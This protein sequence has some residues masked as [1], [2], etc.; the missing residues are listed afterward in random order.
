MTTTQAT[1][2]ANPS[3]PT[4]TNAVRQPNCVITGTMSSGASNAPTAVPLWKMPLPSPRSAGASTVAV[5]RR[6]HGQLNDSPT[7]NPTRVMAND[8]ADPTNPAAA[9][10]RDQTTTAAG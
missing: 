3:A 2:Q 8:P 9:P 4:A 1:T 6:A 10:N 7:A 5:V